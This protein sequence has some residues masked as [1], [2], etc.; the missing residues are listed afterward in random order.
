MIHLV[1]NLSSIETYFVNRAVI[2]SS[3]MLKG[4]N[5]EKDFSIMFS[6]QNLLCLIQFLKLI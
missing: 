2:C 5:N 4:Y 6:V 3:L 1:G